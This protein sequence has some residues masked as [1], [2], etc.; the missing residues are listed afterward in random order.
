MPTGQAGYDPDDYRDRRDYDRERQREQ[1][2]SDRQ[3]MREQERRDFDRDQWERNELIRKMVNDDNVVITSGEMKV[4]NNPEMK[5]LEDGTVVRKS[6]GLGSGA[7]AQ[8]FS[9]LRGKFPER[10]IPKKRSKGRKAIDKLQSLAFKE[11]NKRY[12]NKDGS[13]KKGRTQK[14]I[15]KL[16]Q[17]LLRKYRKQKGI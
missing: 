15:A 2:A 16:A 13:L 3:R 10:F 11:A 9:Q 5:M 6:R 8:Q 14:D 1:E 17:F 4:I 7:F 12:R